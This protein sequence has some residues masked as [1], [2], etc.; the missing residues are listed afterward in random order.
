MKEYPFYTAYTHLNEFYGITMQDDEFETMAITAWDKIGNKRVKLYKYEIEPLQGPVDDEGFPGEYYID[1][2][3]N[4]DIVE[5]VV[6][7]YE[8]YQK[9]SNAKR[10]SDNTNGWKEGYTESRKFNTNHLYMPGK[11]I[12]YRREGNRL[13][14]ADRFNLVRILYK[15]V[16]SDESGLPNLNEK[17]LDAIAAFCAYSRTFK[18]ALVTRNANTMKFAEV[19]KAEWLH[20]CTQSRVPNY[21]NQNELDEILNV[22]VSWDR[23]RF[24]RSFKPIR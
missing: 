16:I 23:K 22:G 24:G 2:P 21:M 14:L 11:Y 1:L 4:A 15:G 18:E 9:T 3:C 13:Y 5:A 19:L 8:D 20:K 17:E 10:S 7:D 12:K 6:A